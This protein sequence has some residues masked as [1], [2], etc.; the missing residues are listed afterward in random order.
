VRV[1]PGFNGTL[2]LPWPSVIGVSLERSGA[3][4]VWV[5]LQRRWKFCDRC[6]RLVRATHVTNV[7]CHIDPGGSRWTSSSAASVRGSSVWA[8]RRGEA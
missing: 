3:V 5:R 2:E 1:T 4:A 8:G 7:R 6:G